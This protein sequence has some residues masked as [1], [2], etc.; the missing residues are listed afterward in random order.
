MTLALRNIGYTTVC[1]LIWHGR[2]LVYVEPNATSHGQIDEE[3]LEADV[4]LR[5][6]DESPSMLTENVVYVALML[7]AALLVVTLGGRET[8]RYRRREPLPAYGQHV[9]QPAEPPAPPSSV[10]FRSDAR[11]SPRS[12]GPATS[13]SRPDLPPPPRTPA[14]AAPPSSAST[15]DSRSAASTAQRRRQRPVG[16]STPRPPRTPAL[17]TSLRMRSR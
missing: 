1:A 9:Q 4:P 2:R 14:I 13:T 12:S 7:F 16:G 5:T 15:T 3:T 6:E 8:A 10:P 17:D 11:A